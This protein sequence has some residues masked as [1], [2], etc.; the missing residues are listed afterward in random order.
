MFKP[1]PVKVE[2]VFMK[3]RDK[4]YLDIETS[5]FEPTEG[6]CIFSIAFI[7]EKHEPNSDESTLE[8]LEVVILPTEEQ[9]KNASPGALKV[10]GITWEYLEKEGVPLDEAKM[11][12][13][14][15]LR[16]RV[17]NGTDTFLVGQ[18]PKFDLKFF[19]Y[20]MKPELDFVGFPWNDVL[21]NIDL[22][23]ALKK[24]DP[25]INSPDNKGHSIS[26]AIG[27]EEED[28]V[29]TAIGGAR[30]VYRNFN[31]IH[32]KVA[33]VIDAYRKDAIEGVNGNAILLPVQ[34]NTF[35]E[36]VEAATKK[37]GWTQVA[38]DAHQFVDPDGIRWS[39]AAGSPP[40]LIKL[41]TV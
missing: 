39:Y 35:K 8:E 23:K 27:V 2:S 21:D 30:V 24:I 33:E 37:L 41:T 25:T 11:K 32:A 9:W 10:N 29:H 5:G 19:K 14:S 3:L 26:R 34:C 18:N 40:I 4:L 17:G 31:G 28:V 13:I 20:F 7:H 1:D 6:A 12:I 36:W 15:W 16:G 22:F 38:V